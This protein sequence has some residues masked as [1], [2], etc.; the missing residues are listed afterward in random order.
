MIILNQKR[1]DFCEERE[2]LWN[3]IWPPEQPGLYDDHFKHR[4][5]IEEE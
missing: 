3:R 2:K 4:Q 1:H 5:K